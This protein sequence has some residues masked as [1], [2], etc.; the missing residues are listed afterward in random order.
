MDMRIQCRRIH[1]DDAGSLILPEIRKGEEDSVII[2]NI[3]TVH[4]QFVE[5]VDSIRIELRI[6]SRL[7]DE[8]L[9]IILGYKEIRN[10]KR[11]IVDISSPDIEHPCNLIQ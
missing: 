10:H 6:R 9:D 2:L 8:P 11:I 7:L 5:T 4:L 1:E 3:H